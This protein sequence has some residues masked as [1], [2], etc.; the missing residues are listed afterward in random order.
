MKIFLLILSLSISVFAQQNVSEKLDEKL[1]ELQVKSGFPGF[2]VAIVN[3][4]GALYQN[5][6]GV[7]D[8]KK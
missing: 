3:E 7:A 5:G 1:R 4:N 6:F 2:A 8:V